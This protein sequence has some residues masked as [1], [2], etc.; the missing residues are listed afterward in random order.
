M[1]ADLLYTVSLWST[2]LYDCFLLI[3]QISDLRTLQVN[4]VTGQ[5]DASSLQTFVTSNVLYNVEL[6]PVEV[7]DSPEMPKCVLSPWK[8]LTRLTDSFELS[9]T[10]DSLENEHNSYADVESCKSQSSP[11]ELLI[12]RNK[13]RR[14]AHIS[15]CDMVSSFD[16]V[17]FSDAGK[18]Y[19]YPEVKSSKSEDVMSDC[20]PK[21]SGVD[22]MLGQNSVFESSKTNGDTDHVRWSNSSIEQ[23]TR[24]RTSN[25][26]QEESLKGS[27]IARYGHSQKY[28]FQLL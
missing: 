5:V 21:E 24:L 7:A 18:K 16:H 10:R 15:Y 27:N 6:S 2:S 20:D 14:R 3:C 17:S 12:G 8:E 25:S 23:A 26:S 9:I 19:G 22:N 28:A 11:D 4:Q 13:E 1:Q